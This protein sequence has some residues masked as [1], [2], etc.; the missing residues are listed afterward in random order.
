MIDFIPVKKKQ[1]QTRLSPA[2]SISIKQR[3]I[4]SFA[5]KQKYSWEVPLEYLTP[6]LKAGGQ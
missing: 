3:A 1:T 4:D 2:P 6:S 5:E